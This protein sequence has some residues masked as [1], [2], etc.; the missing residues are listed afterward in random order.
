MI[1]RLNLLV[2]PIAATVLLHG[3]LIWAVVHVWQPPVQAPNFKK[4]EF[5]KATLVELKAK[6]PEKKASGSKIKKIDLTAKNAKAA[7]LE[8]RKQQEAATQKAQ[9]LKARQI[10]EQKA[11]AAKQKAEQ[12]KAATEAAKRKK[13]AAEKRAREEARKLQQEAINKALREEEMMLAEQAEAEVV[14]SYKSIIAERIINK[15]SRPPSARRGM[16][17][18]LVIQLVP[19]GKIITVNITKSSG[20]QAFDRSAE[21]AVR[22]VDQIPELQNMDINTFERNFRTIHLQFNPEDR[23]L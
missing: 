7:A 1:D 18:D 16:I 14:N 6:A 20:N 13:A 22:A 3:L 12:A 10:K 21:Q 4:P 2:F 19:T 5:V 23:R 8:K 15:W 17:C 11:K 9:Q